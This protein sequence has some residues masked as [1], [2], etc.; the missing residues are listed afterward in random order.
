MWRCQRPVGLKTP[1]KEERDNNVNA[2][3]NGENCCSD[4]RLAESLGC[5]G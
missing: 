4:G 5:L 1:S 2:S 3:L